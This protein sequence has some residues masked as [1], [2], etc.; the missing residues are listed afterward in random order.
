MATLKHFAVHSQP[1]SGTNIGPANYSER[2]VREYFLRP[3]E[4]AIAEA[5]VRTVM[6]SYNELDGIPNHTNSWL[7]QDVLRK[8]WGFKGITVSDYFAVE[9][10]MTIHHVAADCAEAA[11][12]AINAGVDME[13]PWGKCYDTL[14]DLVKKGDVS[15]SAI[16]EAVAR[17]LHAKFEL[18]LFDR[19]YVDAQ[20]ST[21]VSDT[22]EHRALALQAA[23]EAVILL[24]NEKETLPLNVEK[25]KTIAVIG[26]NAGE[27]HLGGYSG[28]PTHTVSILQGIKDR[29][30]AKVKVLYAEGCR[31]T[32]SLPDWNADKVV[33]ADPM[34]DEKRMAEAVDTLKQADL[35]VV[36]VGENEQTSRE[37]WADNH[38]GD[39][40]D[41][42]LYGRQDE[43]VKRLI[44]TG[45][46]V[47]VVLQHGRPN[48]IVYV[49]EHANAILD[50]WY[51]G[52]EGG[53][54]VA[55]ALFG[56]FS[57]AGRLPIT[58]PRNVGQLPAYYYA[59][60]SAKR[61]YLFSSN[62]P[63]FPFGYGLSYSSFSYDH[64]RVTPASIPANGNASIEV[65]ITNTG[66]RDADEV[67][68][69]YIR[70]EL[71]SVTR[72][73]KELR[74]FERVALKRGETKTVRFHV[75]PSELQFYDRQMK[76]T[77]EP[78]TFKIMVGP[79]SVQL[80]EA[81]LT[82]TGP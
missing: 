37:A 58:V 60:P 38:L 75:G 10:L 51:L 9:Q 11:K 82:V 78:G 35:G 21:T 46:P 2:T 80:K 54:A 53:T 19:P 28:K 72:P 59:K 36:V 39:R 14:P 47:I 32:E 41:L 3:F 56:D 26:P 24:K 43:L 18:G 33:P 66:D 1:E 63:L 16:N 17:V 70:D 23:R 29:V 64:L 27:A 52:Q 6:P 34:L 81:V 30:G 65:D 4:S 73:T 71:S 40:D 55:Q 31:I 79:D 5:Q 67:A 12:L 42:N 45:K 25:I 68:Q 20:R 8:E 69:L 44:A 77:V 62:A 48:S 13:L 22:P 74:G 7:L 50:G 57:P 15:E 61:G 49:A 76:R